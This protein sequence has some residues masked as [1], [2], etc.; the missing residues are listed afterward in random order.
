[1]LSNESSRSQSISDLDDIIPPQLV[2]YAIEHG[3]YTLTEND[4]DSSPSA[5]AAKML[6]RQR[7]G[8]GVKL[9]DDAADA[10]RTPGVGQGSCTHQMMEH[11][12]MV[13]PGQMDQQ[14]QYHQHQHSIGDGAASAWT[15][16]PEAYTRG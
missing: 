16:I 9:V 13:M 7:Y 14:Q 8:T 3:P 5:S 15:N 4:T 12:E 6:R 2:Q 11:H 10:T 1:M